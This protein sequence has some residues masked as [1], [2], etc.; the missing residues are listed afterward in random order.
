ML[1]LALRDAQALLGGM[2]ERSVRLGCVKMNGAP[3]FQL[4]PPPPPPQKK[5]KKK[6]KKKKNYLI[7]TDE[8]EQIFNMH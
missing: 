6:K 1:Q 2:G 7:K 5:K 3:S 8:C 4:P